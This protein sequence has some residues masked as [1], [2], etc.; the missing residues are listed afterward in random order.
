MST[1]SFDVTTVRPRR[2]LRWSEVKRHFENGGTARVCTT[3]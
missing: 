3:S 2:V 1:M